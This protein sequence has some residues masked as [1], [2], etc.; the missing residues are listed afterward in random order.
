MF[1]RRPA[2][3]SRRRTVPPRVNIYFFPTILGFILGPVQRKK[4]SAHFSKHHDSSF[5]NRKL[6]TD[7][8]IFEIFQHQPHLRYWIF[9]LRS[10]FQ[11]KKGCDMAP[12]KFSNKNDSPSMETALDEKKWGF[13]AVGLK[14][15]KTCLRTCRNTGLTMFLRSVQNFSLEDRV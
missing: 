3:P 15:L 11:S 6:F 9:E 4:K 12:S 8:M 10:I 14:F 7:L 1:T 2:V 5:F 13:L